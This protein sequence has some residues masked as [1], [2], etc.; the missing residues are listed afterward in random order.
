MNMKKGLL[1]TVKETVN[2]LKDVLCFWKFIE[3]LKNHFQ[4]K[5]SKWELYVWALEC[6]AQPKVLLMNKD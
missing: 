4:K 3:K 5:S 2:L 6:Q 1:K